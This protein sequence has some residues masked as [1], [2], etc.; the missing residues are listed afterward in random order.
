MRLTYGRTF[1]A[2]SIWMLVGL[3]FYK[4]NFDIAWEVA[5]YQ[6]VSIGYNVGWGFPRERDDGAKIF[7]CFYLFIGEAATTAFIQYFIERAMANR[8]TWIADSLAESKLAATSLAEHFRAH[9]ALYREKYAVIVLWISLNFACGIYSCC[10]VGWNGIQGFYFAISVLGTGGLWPI[11][12]DS[13]DSLFLGV[14]FFE[15][16]GVPFTGVVMGILAEQVISNCFDAE[17]AEAIIHEPVSEEEIQVL[18]QVG[19][20]DGDK[21]LSRGEYIILCAMRL[22][23]M[24]PAVV[25]AVYRN[26]L[27]FIASGFVFD[28]TFSKHA[29]SQTTQQTS[30]EPDASRLPAPVPLM[31]LPTRLKT[32]ILRTGSVAQQDLLKLRQH[33]KKRLY[34]KRTGWDGIRSFMSSMC[35]PDRLKRFVFFIAVAGWILVGTLVYALGNGL[36]G[37]AGFYQAVSVGMAVGWAPSEKYDGVILFATFFHLIGLLCIGCLLGIFIEH[38]LEKDETWFSQEIHE[39][40]VAGTDYY[41]SA[42]RYR[43]HNSNSL[44]IVAVWFLFLT[45]FTILAL[46]AVPGWNVTSSRLPSLSILLFLLPLLFF[47]PFPFHSYSFLS[48]LLF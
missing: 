5:L 15:L 17:D 42:K 20:E 35:A 47:F 29:M 8:K 6:T 26:Y 33:I 21:I 48:P 46:C 27:K 36:G 16:F 4:Y 28:E 41:H 22:G 30:E 24:Q 14:A 13:P 44:R 19:F 37:V 1:L 34:L 32:R 3:L 38:A 45:G 31:G 40:E 39:L 2:W 9:I 25:T 12:P 10:A 7:S 23:A 43:I 11:P 18:S